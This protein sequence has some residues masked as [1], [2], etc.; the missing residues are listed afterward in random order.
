MRATITFQI[1]GKT[2][3]QIEGKLTERICSY[4]K[5]EDYDS[6]K[7]KVDI[8]MFIFCGE[9]GPMDL[10]FSADCKVKVKS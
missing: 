9:E 2:K 3:E 4:F 1:T 6:I 10:T 8:E 5:V 7:E